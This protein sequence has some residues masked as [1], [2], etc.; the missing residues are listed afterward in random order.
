MKVRK[1]CT[2]IKMRVMT[3]YIVALIGVFF[4][5]IHRKHLLTL[6]SNEFIGET[7]FFI[8]FMKIMY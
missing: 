6:G 3:R 5:S 1:I 8:T 2:N 7:T 4:R